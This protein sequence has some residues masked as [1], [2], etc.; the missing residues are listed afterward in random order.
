MNVLLIEDETAAAHNLAAILHKVVPE[1][2]IVD[3]IDTVVDSIEWLNSN[4]APDLIFMDIHLSDGESFRIFDSVKIETPIIF[5]TAYDQYA[6]KAFQVS[7]ID[8]LRKPINEQSVERAI[9]KWRVLT[10]VAERKEY[11]SRV[12][13]LAHRRQSECPT[14]LV[15]FRDKIIPL[16]CDDIAYCYTSDE[17]VSAYS[18]SGDRYPLEYTLETLQGMLPQ[19][20]F[21]RA[22]RQFIVS[23]RAIADISIWFG[24]RLALNLSPQA[25]EK[26]V[27]SKA[28]VPEFKAWLTN[29]ADE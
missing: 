20:R 7:S 27:I 26:L 9:A 19:S 2:Q 23:R 6:L 13:E 10:N 3:T 5:T 12:E 22:N 4:P 29:S 17:K 18:H 16:S 14:F 28:R 25:P 24:S 1:V 8:Y 15:R 21:F 11:A